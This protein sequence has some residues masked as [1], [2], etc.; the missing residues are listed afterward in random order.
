M[1]TFKVRVPWFGVSCIEKRDQFPK[2]ERE[3]VLGF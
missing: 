1:I 3:E 2:E